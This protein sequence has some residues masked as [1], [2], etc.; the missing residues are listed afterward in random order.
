MTVVVTLVPIP[1]PLGDNSVTTAILVM[2][3][4]QDTARS[5]PMSKLLLIS[6][7]VATVNQ[8]QARIANYWQHQLIARRVTPGAINVKISASS[9]SITVLSDNKTYDYFYNCCIESF[10][11]QNRVWLPHPWSEELS[12]PPTAIPQIIRL[13]APEL[14]KRFYSQRMQITQ[15]SIVTSNMKAVNG[16]RVSRNYQHYTI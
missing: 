1:M 10:L 11:N 15:Q 4:S 9:P 7:R 6:G 14:A 12:L 5:G 13:A 8:F 16:Q 3:R 2:T